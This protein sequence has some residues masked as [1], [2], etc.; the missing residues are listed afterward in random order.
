MTNN[1]HKSKHVTAVGIDYIETVV[2]DLMAKSFDAYQQR[3]L[4]R[5]QFQTSINE[6][7]NATAGILLTVIA[8][9]TIRN[10]I[11]Y[12][13]NTTIKNHPVQE[14]ANTIHKK[15]PAFPKDKFVK[16]LNEIF[17]MRDVIAHN[18]LYEVEVEYKG[19]DMLPPK[20][21]LLKGYG[22]D[23]KFENA[24]NHG[25]NKTKLLKLNVQ[26]AKIGFDDLFKVLVL[27]DLIDGVINN[28]LWSS[29]DHLPGSH[30][31]DGIWTENLS[32]VLVHYF[33]KLPTAGF[34]QNVEEVAR[35]LRKDFATF[36]PQ[37]HTE[38][39]FF[40]NICPKCSKLGFRKRPT[41]MSCSKC[42]AKKSVD[43]PY[44]GV[45]TG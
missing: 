28:V 41:L 14:L 33:D 34:A 3:D 12:H 15:E 43:G 36:I 10:E 32:E 31:I 19:R 26:P 2:L 16:L 9:E 27:L 17:V 29:N 13:T 11:Y 6:H 18:H 23:K 7:A 8:V 45:E 5:P 37:T 1:T 20:N 4:T 21:T 39:W 22:D 35:L 25:D 44:R 40:T 42:G 24:V 38:Y 30:E